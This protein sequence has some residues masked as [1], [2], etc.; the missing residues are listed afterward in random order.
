M[1]IRILLSNVA[2][3]QKTKTDGSNSIFNVVGKWKT[4]TE[5]RIPFSDDV[6][7]RKTKLEVRIPVSYF[8]GKRLAQRRLD[9]RHVTNFYQSDSSLN[10]LMA[11]PE[12][13]PKARVVAVV[14]GFPWFV[15]VFRRSLVS[16][17][18]S[19]RRDG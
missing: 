7:N 18:P 17:L 14:F 19:P 15:F 2:G 3:K 9:N 8:A 12:N 1:T 13:F 10:M 4:K 5:S 16:G 11:D 6:G